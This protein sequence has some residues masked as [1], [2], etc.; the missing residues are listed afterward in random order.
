MCAARLWQASNDFTVIA[1]GCTEF[2]PAGGQC[3]ISVAFSPLT[4]SFKSFELLLFG[5][6]PARAVQ[7]Q[8]LGTGGIAAVSTEVA[9]NGGGINPFDGF[10]AWCALVCTPSRLPHP[11]EAAAVGA[12][13][14]QDETGLRVAK[15][16]DPAD[17]FC[18]ALPQPT[19]DPALPLVGLPS[20]ANY[21][22][23]AFYYAVGSDVRARAAACAERV[24]AHGLC[25]R[26]RRSCPPRVAA[27]CCA[28]ATSTWSPPWS[29]PSTPWETRCR[30][31]RSSSPACASA[32]EA[33][34][35]THSVR[36]PA[37]P[38]LTLCCCV[39]FLPQH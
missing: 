37:P 9:V 27:A 11:P 13:R 1:N 35:P 15:C 18:N 30:T 14:Y 10:P 19:F 2:V 12:R 25:L 22:G 17:P 23:E 38:P 5:N 39:E 21:P 4:A 16:I 8:G 3:T 29:A 26:V 20:F 34:A 7:L 24:R 33:C 6:A 28:R 36:V 32:P 31:R